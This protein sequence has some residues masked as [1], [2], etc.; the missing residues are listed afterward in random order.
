MRLQRVTIWDS[1]L[2]RHHIL[3]HTNKRHFKNSHKPTTKN[4]PI[5]NPID[6]H[7]I[8]IAT[9]G[10]QKGQ[11]KKGAKQ[12]RTRQHRKSPPRLWTVGFWTLCSAPSASSPAPARIIS[13]KP[14]FLPKIPFSQL[15]L[16]QPFTKVIRP[17]PVYSEHKFF[18]T[19]N[20]PWALDFGPGTH[21]Y[22]SS[23]QDTLILHLQPEGGSAIFATTICNR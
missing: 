17:S 8:N 21:I 16:R 7:V 6:T 2:P 1:S 19:S 13:P 20:R 11:I 9:E 14:P 18:S 5:A 12:G 3:Y 10:G 15:F 23:H 4:S 22:I